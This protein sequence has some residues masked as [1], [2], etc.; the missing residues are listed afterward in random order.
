MKWY[1]QFTPHDTYDFDAEETPVLIDIDYHGKPRKLLI[2]ANRNGFVYL[3]DRTNG[4]FLSA[5]RF[6]PRVNWAT[7]IDAKGRPIS[8]QLQ[9]SA[10]GTLICPGVV[11]ATN[12]YSPSWNQ[13]TGLF[14]FMTLDSCSI[15]TTR[16]QEFV[17]GRPFYATGS[18]D[19]PDGK[20]Q[21]VLVAF[22]P[23]TNKIAWKYPQAGDG[24][25]WGGVMSTATGVVFFAGLGGFFEAAEGRS[26]KSL[27]HFNTGQQLHASPMSYAVD[28]KQYVAIASGDDLFSFALP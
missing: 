9:P 28:G 21:A 15:I 1:F 26:G 5:K 8:A 17:P 16:P 14:Y 10:S 4:H 11:G 3:L 25:P 20:S 19:A 27:W 2:E 23:Q 7:G 22:D 13:R 6:V 24:Q 18:R 12:W